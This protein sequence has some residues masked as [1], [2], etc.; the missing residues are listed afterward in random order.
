M[1]WGS[2]SCKRSTKLKMLWFSS[3]SSS[4]ILSLRQSR[5]V[6]FQPNFHL[7]IKAS[8]P[9]NRTK[10]CF[11]K[12]QMRA[13]PAALCRTVCWTSRVAKSSCRT[14]TKR[15]RQSLTL[16]LARSTLKKRRRTR[17]T[18]SSRS[19]KGR[20]WTTTA[21]KRGSSSFKYSQRRRSS[22]CSWIRSRCRKLTSKSL[23]RVMSRSRC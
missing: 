20:V 18:S 9:N 19:G 4:P 6:I 5:Q 14:S 22:W 17:K 23:I 13:N 16:W 12:M 1:G 2:T 7:K 10:T 11:S 8:T 21:S 3:I 15:C